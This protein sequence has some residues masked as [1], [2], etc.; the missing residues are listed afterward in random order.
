MIDDGMIEACKP[1][2]RREGCKTDCGVSDCACRQLCAT[3]ARRIARVVES[4][5]LLRAAQIPLFVLF[6]L[7]WAPL[8]GCTFVVV[9]DVDLMWMCR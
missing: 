7:A 6:V 1:C 5:R 8:S 9:H 4:V 2:M 3:C